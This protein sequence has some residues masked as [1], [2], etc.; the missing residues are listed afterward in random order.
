MSYLKLTAKDCIKILAV[1]SLVA[2]SIVSPGIAVAYN[3]L[4]KKWKKYNRGDIGKLIKRFNNQKLLDFTEKNGKTLIKLSDKGKI[5]LLKYNFDEISLNKRRD[6][7]QRLLIFDIPNKQKTAR[8]ILRKKLKDLEFKQVQ[9][10]VFI[11]PYIC[12]KE[13]SFV[14][15]FLN[16]SKFVMLL[17]I[18]KVEIGPDF[19]FKSWTK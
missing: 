13:I 10:S 6:G 5:K 18:D 14:I 9:E 11:S 19:I 8:E 2:A 16:I 1:T 3:N 7:N 17:K 12:D 4:D 15:N